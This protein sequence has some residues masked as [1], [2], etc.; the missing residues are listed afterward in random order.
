MDAWHLSR[1]SLTTTV[2]YMCHSHNVNKRASSLQQVVH[3]AT[4]N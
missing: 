3:L 4:G 1:S 2:P